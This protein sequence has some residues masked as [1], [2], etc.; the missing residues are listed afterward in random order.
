[1]IIENLEKKL[2]G[3]LPVTREELKELI[4]SWG[5]IYIDD[6]SVINVGM[7]YD[8]SRL[9]VSEITDMSSLFNNSPFDGDISSWNTSNVTD[10]SY[11]FY[12]TRL[13]NQELNFDTS[14]VTNMKNMFHG[15]NKFNQ[16]VIFDT[17]NVTTMRRMFSYARSFNQPIN[18]DTSKVTNMEWMFNDAKAFLDRYNKGETLLDYTD[19]IKEWLNDNRD[20]MNEIDIKENHGE[21]IDDFF[22]NITDIYSTN[23]IGLHENLLTE[24]NKL[25]L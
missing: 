13:F 23:R 11:M 2:N 17:S 18:F 19:K 24:C 9:D 3:E 16:P 15:A 5:E 25:C 1:M 14:K 4:K 21:E 10:M 6:K 7:C 8:L 20:R 22:S 12:N